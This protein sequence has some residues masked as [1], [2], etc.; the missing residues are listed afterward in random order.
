MRLADTLHLQWA[1]IEQTLARA[2][3]HRLCILDCCYS[4]NIARSVITT[5]QD[6]HNFEILSA[7]SY[8]GTTP[9]PGD[10]S[11][12]SALIW[13]LKSLHDEFMEKGFTTTHLRIKIRQ[14]P[15]FP[16]D[17]RPAP[18]KEINT[19]ARSRI[20][21]HPLTRH[22]SRTNSQQSANG[23][24]L[25]LSTPTTDFSIGRYV[26]NLRFI[27]QEKPTREKID[28][29]ATSM[30]RC[31]EEV[32]G[33]CGVGW[34]G[35][36]KI[37]SAQKA[38]VEMFKEKASRRDALK[39]DYAKPFLALLKSRKP[40]SEETSTSNRTRQNST[41]NNSSLQFE[42]NQRTKEL[43]RWME[44]ESSIA[45]QWPLTPINAQRPHSTL[46]SAESS[47][48]DQE[49]SEETVPVPESTISLVS[50]LPHLAIFL[51]FNIIFFASSD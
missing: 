4:G 17:Q 36:E 26:V 37:G 18:V 50:I 13:A 42:R 45:H 28:E 48:K 15:D 41:L 19:H 24:L 8:G 40:N 21:L 16:R 35:L 11:F 27:L 1:T 33:L 39:R 7:S 43:E 23:L 44:S 14:A 47:T 31:R 12:T 22:H 5:A 49:G 30:K 46:G 3:G 2:H 51:G 32:N 34:D 6:H 25:P 38:V 10:H 29:L 20:V 9:G